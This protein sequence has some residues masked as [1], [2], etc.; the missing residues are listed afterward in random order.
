MTHEIEDDVRIFLRYLIAELK[1]GREYMETG[2]WH[3][4]CECLDC[5]NME[6]WIKLSFWRKLKAKLFL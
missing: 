2:N 6:R 5:R 1:Q 3:T 4:E